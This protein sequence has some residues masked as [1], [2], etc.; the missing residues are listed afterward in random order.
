M[1][2]FNRIMTFVLC[3]CC[4][5]IC[6][7]GCSLWT[8]DTNKYL[9]Q[10]VA[11]YGEVTVTLEETYNAY[12]SYGNYYYDNQQKV[13]YEGIKKTAQQL[14]N[15]KLFVDELKDKDS[16]HYVV[17]NQNELNDVWES[18]YSAINSNITSIEKKLLSAD[19]LS[20]LD[21]SEEEEEK[22][23]GYEKP[24][25]AYNKTYEYKNGE[26][27]KIAKVPEETENYSEDI[28]QFTEEEMQGFENLEAK[29]ESL[30]KKTQA[31]RAFENFKSTRWD[32]A[33]HQQTNKDGVKYSTKALN[34]Y[35]SNL[36]S[37]EQGKNLSTASDEVFYREVERLFKSYHENK[38]L[39]VFQEDFNANDVMSEELILDTFN[40]LAKDQKDTY[41]K[42]IDKD[43]NVAYPAY[44]TAMKDRKNPI[45]YT[46]QGEDWFQVS[47]I[48]LKFSDD[49]VKDLKELKAKLEKDAILEE[50]YITQVNE[51]KKNV[52]VTDRETGK[53]VKATEVLAKLQEELQGL[54]SESRIQKFNE[55]IYRY[56]MDDGVNNA[57]FAYYIPVNEKND[58]MVTPFANESRRLRSLGV[59]SIS[60]LIE[61]NEV[62][63]YTDNNDEKQTPGYS[64]YHIIMYLGEIP[65]LP[66][67][68]SVT[69]QQLN[70]HILNPLNNNETNSKTM[71]DYTIEQIEYSNYS[72]YESTIL[73]GLRDEKD[74][75]FYSGVINQLVS[76]FS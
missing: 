36:R 55:F 3:L 20:L 73:A 35:I 7:S 58:S 31:T 63:G 66:S 19:D 46:I 39:S 72:S 16:D 24:Y 8:L 62:D 60:G 33:N 38:L 47:H 30:D 68:G 71:L 22:L 69:I 70:D 53:Q 12:Y 49:D 5:S 74:I 28:F 59:G 37:S 4:F 40:N 14:L 23:T 44:T 17:L 57:D 67:N 10:V 9:N 43:G 32:G 64:G 61:V 11:S 41:I 50:D 27:S 48:L 75:N 15:K 6:F 65:T 2:F 52:K 42:V 13:T 51:I 21:T 25:T 26:L 18:V 34:K 76:A 45:M 56:N 29:L 1:K 54:G